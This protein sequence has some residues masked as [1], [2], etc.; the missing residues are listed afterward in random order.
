[1]KNGFVGSKGL[2]SREQSLGY[3]E[4]IMHQDLLQG[5]MRATKS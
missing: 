4:L 1:M 3:G 5:L 2:K